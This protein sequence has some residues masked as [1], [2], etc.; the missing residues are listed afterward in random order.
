MMVANR[1]SPPWNL[2]AFWTQTACLLLRTML[3]VFRGHLSIDHPDAGSAAQ[4]EFERDS[5][6]VNVPVAPITGGQPSSCSDAD[7]QSGL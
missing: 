7:I 3:V 2:V 1:Q 6:A 4:N 5:P